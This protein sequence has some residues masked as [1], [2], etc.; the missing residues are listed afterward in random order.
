MV[1]VIASVHTKG[2]TNTTDV[3]IRRRRAGVDADMLSTKITIG[4][5]Y[6]ASDEVI[7]GNNDDVEDGDQI[8]IDVDAIHTGTAPKGL[9]VVLTF[10]K[11]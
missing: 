2:V 10:R 6:F 8:Y 1:D 9:S 11:P 3:Q 4:D 7:D 5:E